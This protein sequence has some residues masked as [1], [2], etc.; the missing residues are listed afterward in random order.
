[1]VELRKGEKY[2]MS[3]PRHD[4]CGVQNLASSRGNLQQLQPRRNQEMRKS[5]EGHYLVLELVS[6]EQMR[7]K[8]EKYLDHFFNVFH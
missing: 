5:A 7:D 4:T 6:D 1:M 3:L 8:C 2:H